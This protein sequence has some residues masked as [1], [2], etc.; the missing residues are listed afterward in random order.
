MV[1]YGMVWYGMVWYG[2]VWYGMVWYGMVWY[3]QARQG[4][5]RCWNVMYVCVSVSYLL[6]GCVCV[7]WCVF[8]SVVLLFC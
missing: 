5:A 1:W 4:K 6:C 2:M 7:F 3:G 8:L